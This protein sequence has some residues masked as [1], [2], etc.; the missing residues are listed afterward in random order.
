MTFKVFLRKLV[1]RVEVGLDVCRRYT[2]SVRP[3]RHFGMH[4][5]LRRYIQ[6]YGT[7]APFPSFHARSI[8]MAVHPEALQGACMAPYLP[9]RPPS[10]KT[11]H[12][13]I[14]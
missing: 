7:D 8:P 13:L 14:A 9:W 5:H 3:C 4:R 12:L 11:S 6:S 2:H 10:P 1:G